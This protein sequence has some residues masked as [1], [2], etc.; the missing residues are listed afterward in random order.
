MEAVDYMHSNN[1]IHSYLKP[2]NILLTTKKDVKLCDFGTSKKIALINPS[3]FT[4]TLL[5]M[6]PEII[7]LENEN[8]KKS[9]GG[10][11]LSSDVYSL[12]VIFY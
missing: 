11:G 3:T 9:N 4:G 2:S 5:Y 10:Y 12:G 8:E 7:K 6:A 1:I